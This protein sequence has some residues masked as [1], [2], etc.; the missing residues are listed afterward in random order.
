LHR[1]Q[2]LWKEAN[3]KMPFNNWVLY[4]RDKVEERNP[5]LDLYA[6]PREE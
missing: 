2:A 1:A 6:M 3:S 4:F 5:K